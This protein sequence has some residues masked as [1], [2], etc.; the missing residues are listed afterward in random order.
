MPR[1]YF[2]VCDGEDVMHDQI[3]IELDD[4]NLVA[5]HAVRALPEMAHDELPNGPERDFW[6]KVRDETGA[7]IFEA[8]LQFKS[9]W[10]RRR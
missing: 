2:D 10:L 9:V 4:D 5:D 3:G 6:V 1:Y 7:Y 8:D